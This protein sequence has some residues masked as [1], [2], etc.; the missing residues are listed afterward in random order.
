VTGWEWV[1]AAIC[2]AIIVGCWVQA[3]LYL[4]RDEDGS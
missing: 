3:F 1:Y 2:I 4:W